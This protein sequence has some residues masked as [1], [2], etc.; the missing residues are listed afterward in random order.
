MMKRWL[1][2][3]LVTVAA[4]LPWLQI[5]AQAWAQPKVSVAILR[6]QP[7]HSAEQV[8]QVVMGTP[9]K[10]LQK[11]DSWWKIETPEGYT[12]YVRDNTLQGLTDSE[13]QRWRKANR[14]VVTTDRMVYALAEPTQ[15]A[16]RISDLVNGV[17]LRM[18]N[19]DVVNG[20]VSVSLPDG[21]NG[22]I[23]STLIQPIEQWANQTWNPAEMP[24]YAARFMGAPY[25]WGGT[26]LKG[27]DCSGLTQICAYRQGI[28]LPRDASQQV[29]VGTAVSKADY[30][31]FLPGDLLFFGNVATGKITHVAI[32]M[33]GPRYIHSSA[34]V[35]V[36]SLDKSASDYENS[37]LIAVRRID[38]TAAQE[39][40]L[41]N[42]PWYF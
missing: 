5:A 16:D 42:H 1:K 4:L 33:G 28:M 9:L 11:Q 26:S 29:K 12:G 22:Y 7:R 31:Q 39:L 40:A 27:M 13:M 36:S 18:N 14:G 30:T 32:S 3:L 34:R 37:G 10:V 17:I 8:S 38:N 23:D 20:M 2:Y 35:R 15:E 25:V 24:Q 21:R 6:S 41:K 19:E